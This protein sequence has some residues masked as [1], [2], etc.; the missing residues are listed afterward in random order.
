MRKVYLDTVS[1]NRCIGVLLEDAEIV[2]A[3]APIYAMPVNLKNSEYQRFAEEYDIH[4]IFRDAVP[5]VDFY[6]VP[7]V[8]IFAADSFGGYFGSVG[9]QVDL[10]E[11]I[12]ICYIDADKNC[13][14]V[15]ETGNEFLKNAH[16]WK[17]TL[18][19]IS[20]IEFFESFEAARNK[21]EFFDVAKFEQELA[22]MEST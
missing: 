21:Y 17:K 14:L 19:P 7:L 3:G 22:D 2:L 12:P 11:N 13:Y 5:Q 9:H 4:F 18:K 10:Q 6:T 8:E 20:D 16:C 1:T 15:A